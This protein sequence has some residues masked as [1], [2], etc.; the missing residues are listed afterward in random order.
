MAISLFS[1]R[2][3]TYNVLADV[4]TESEVSRTKLFSH[5]PASFI[6]YGYRKLLIAQELLGITIFHTLNVLA[7]LFLQ[8]ISSGNLSFAI[9]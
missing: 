4:Y 1:F 7:N 3:V 6:D 5:C 2:V 9:N 8:I